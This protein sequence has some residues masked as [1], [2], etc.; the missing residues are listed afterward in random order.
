MEV[1]RIGLE[2]WRDALPSS[3]FEVFHHPDVLSVLDA[4]TD[5]ELRLYGGFK[6]QQA[7][8]LV[9]VWVSER[10]VG[11]AVLSPPPSMTVPRLGPLVMPNSPK[12]RKKE[13]LHGEVVDALVEDLTIDDT[14]TLFRMSCPLGFEDPRP[15][16]WHGLDV[17]TLFTY[18]V[19]AEDG[20]IDDVMKSFSR[21]LR[22]DMRKLD[23]VPMS[24]EVGGL[25]A[26]MTV[27]DDLT[28]RYEE[29][30]ETPPA[31]A[32]LVRDIVRNL[33][34]SRC[35]TYVARDDAG[36]YLGGIVVLYSN[37]HAYYWLGGA[38]VT[39]ENVSVNTLL[40]RVIL[41]DVLNDEE[42]ESVTGYDLMGAN[43]ERICKYK[44]KFNGELV[45]YHVAESDSVVMSGA[46]M[47]YQRLL[48]R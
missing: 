28:A 10:A 34:S 19:D 8:A 12:R 23:E 27:Y 1:E 36:D 46:K 14:K 17:D 33:D 11:K 41:E 42:L 2:E 47:A 30:G 31:T 45:P 22:R 35:R 39:R 32:P 24:V 38:R 43:T 20:D 44:A 48:N 15:F 3:G 4:H 13:K 7:V 6:G 29:Q 25:D 5:S 9:P 40:H 16:R 18:V 37:D 21:S 26:A